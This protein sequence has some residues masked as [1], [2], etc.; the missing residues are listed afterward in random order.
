MLRSQ[1]KTGAARESLP[2]GPWK[3]VVLAFLSSFCSYLGSA[4]SL[5]SGGR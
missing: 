1:A 5:L 4:H 3:R 2:A